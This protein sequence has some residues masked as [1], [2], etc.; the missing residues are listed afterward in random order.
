VDTGKIEPSAEKGGKSQEDL[1]T[2]TGWQCLSRI[3]WECKD[4]VKSH[5]KPPLQSNEPYGPTSPKAPQLLKIQ[6]TQKRSFR[7]AVASIIGAFFAVSLAPRDLTG[8]SGCHALTTVP[9][10]QG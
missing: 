10:S 1:F 2:S 9:M 7:V 5:F 4:P 8:E 3:S 6:V